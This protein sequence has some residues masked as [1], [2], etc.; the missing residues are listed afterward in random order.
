MKGLCVWH[1]LLAPSLPPSDHP[2]EVT[3]LHLIIFSVS[4]CT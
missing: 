3:T 2:P 4:L 1:L